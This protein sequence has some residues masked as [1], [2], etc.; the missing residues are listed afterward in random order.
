[1][2]K[3][4]SKEVPDPSIPGIVIAA[5]SL[6]I[7]PILA[8]MKYTT[9]KSL[10]LGSLIADSKETIVCSFLSFALLVGLVT[11]IGLGFW[12]SDPIVG[13][14]IVIYLLKEGF[15]LLFEKEGEGRN[16]NEG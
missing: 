2:R 14:I 3:I 5:L 16:E 10:A 8:R 7:M 11:R 13:F 1:M 4:L 12:L 15:E 9:G 6:V